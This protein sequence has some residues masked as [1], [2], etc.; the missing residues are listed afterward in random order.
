VSEK[1]YLY[2]LVGLTVG[3]LVGYCHPAKAHD[4]D[5]PLICGSV[6]LDRYIVTPGGADMAVAIIP[7]DGSVGYQTMLKPGDAL[8]FLSCDLDAPTGQTCNMSPLAL[9]YIEQP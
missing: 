2:I 4:P 9:V 5:P 6:A 3:Y 7:A 8:R 1:Q